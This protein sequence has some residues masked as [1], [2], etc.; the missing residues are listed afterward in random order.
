[1]ESRNNRY[2][3]NIEGVDGEM[4]GRKMIVP[5][6]AKCV[7]SDGLRCAK[8]NAAKNDLADHGVDIFHC[9]SF[10]VKKDK[11]M[12]ERVKTMGFSSGE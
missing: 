12:V 3:E 7:H 11:P 9:P 10:E 2:T 5:N 4:V 6:C 1:M 8:M